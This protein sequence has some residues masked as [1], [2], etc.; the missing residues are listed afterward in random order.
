MADDT[1]LKLNADGSLVDVEP[2]RWLVGFVPPID[3]QWWHGLVHHKHK[4]C[5]AMHRTDMNTWVIFEPWWTRLMV[6]K[7]D[8]RQA[9]KFLRWSKR[10]D[11]LEVDEYVPGNSSQLRGWMTCAALVAHLLGRSYMVWTPHKLYLRLLEEPATIMIE[12]DRWIG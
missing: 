5:F 10:G 11:L 8:N 4:H 2:V 7:I 3:R 6:G 1:E 9:Q 12:P